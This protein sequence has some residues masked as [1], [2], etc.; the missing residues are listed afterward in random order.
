VLSSPVQERGLAQGGSA[1]NKRVHR[2]RK[3]VNLCCEPS[4]VPALEYGNSAAL[5][6]NRFLRR[7]YRPALPVSALFTDHPWHH[8]KRRKPCATCRSKGKWHGGEHLSWA[9]QIQHTKYKN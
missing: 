6:H 7:C 4:C 9:H 5:M 1:I 3:F 8:L 2:H